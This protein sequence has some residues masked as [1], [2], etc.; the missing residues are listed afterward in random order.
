MTFFFL[1][2]ANFRILKLN[3]RK[4]LLCLR[5]DFANKE[6]DFLKLEF[7]KISQT[8]QFSRFFESSEGWSV[9]CV[10]HEELFGGDIFHLSAGCSK[11]V[12]AGSVLLSY[13]LVVYFEGCKRCSKYQGKWLHSLICAF[14]LWE[15]PS[16]FG[17]CL[18][19]WK[20]EV[21]LRRSKGWH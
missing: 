12:S 7:E 9:S 16:F 15:P 17:L 14:K 18:L 11:Y 6:K 8:R 20:S 1:N 4:V 10:G 2:W 3:F 5:S 21:F 19:C 13:L